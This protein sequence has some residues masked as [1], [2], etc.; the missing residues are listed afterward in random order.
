MPHTSTDALD[1]STRAPHILQETVALSQPVQRVVAFA[2]GP[3]ESAERVRLV[4][5]RVSAILVDLADADLDRGVVLGFDDAVGSAALARDIT[6]GGLVN[7]LCRGILAPRYLQV[8]DLT[9]LVFHDG[10]WGISKWEL[11]WWLFDFDVG[12]VLENLANIVR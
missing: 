11:C 7:V 10:C 3:D 12:W 4:L 5:P 8:N 9:L 2:H 6:A 1:S